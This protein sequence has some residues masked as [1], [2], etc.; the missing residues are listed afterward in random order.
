MAKKQNKQMP[1]NTVQTLLNEDIKKGK[2]A[3]KRSPH[4]ETARKKHLKDNPACAACGNTKNVQVHHIRPFHLFPELELEPTNFISLCETE[5]VD[6]DKTNDNHHLHLGH[7]G[8]FHKNNEKVLEDVDKYR[9]EKLKLP[10][11]EGYDFK[12]LKKIL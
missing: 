4:W 5:V 10:K 2:P 6:D 7:G 9:Q 8:D 11:L 3:V 1:V 12:N